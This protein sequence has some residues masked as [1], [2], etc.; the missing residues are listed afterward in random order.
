M[1]SYPYDWKGTNPENAFH[2]DW[3]V[4][5]DDPENRVLMLKHRPF[6]GTGL[7]V[8]AAGSTNPLTL[9]VDYQLAYQLPELEDSVASPVFCGV[10]LLNPLIGGALEITGQTLGDTFYSPFIDMLDD[11]VKYLNNPVDVD[12]LKLDGRPTLYPA[13]PAATSWADLLNKKYLASA[14]RDVELDAGAANDLIRDKLAALKTTVEGLQTEIAAFNYP[15]H[16]AEHKAHDITGAQTGAHPAN[17][18]TPDT[19]LAYGKTLRTLTAEI[20]ALGLQQSDIDNYIEKWACKDVNGVFVQTL[21]ANRQLFKSKSGTSEITFTDTAFTIKTNGSVILS[22]GYDEAATV[23]FMEWK[24]GVNTLR[25]E[26]SGSAL[27][28]DKLTLNDRVLLTTNLLLEYQSD[29]SEGGNTDPDDNKLWVQGRNGLSFTGKGSRADPVKGTLTPPVASTTVKGITKLK[30][31]PGPETNL[32]STPA[33]L[34]PYE[35][36][37]SGYVPKTTMINSGAMDTGSRTLVKADIGLGNVDNTK[38][39]DKPISQEQQVDL[40]ELSIK[41]HK[42]AWDELLLPLASNN[43]KGIARYTSLEDGL[44][45]QK[46]VAPNLLKALS[47][48]LDIVAAA[49]SDVKTGASTDFAAVDASTWTV[50]GTKRGLTVQDMDYFYLSQ[51]EKKSGVVSGTIDLQ[52]TPMFQWFSPYNAMERTWPKSV[53]NGTLAW[54]GISNQPALPLL[55]V[56]VGKTVGQM[57]DL[58]V[59]SILSKERV[60]THTGKLDIYVA[61]GGKVTVYV[62][63]VEKIAANSPAYVNV[64]FDN[65]DGT[66]HTVAI[67]ADCTDVAKPA[68]MMYE[69]WDGKAPLVRSDVGKP[70]AQLQEF[71]TQAD[72]LRHYLYLNMITGSIYSRAEPVESQDID[73]EHA[74]IGYVDLP[75]GGLTVSSVSFPKTFDFGMAKELSD[76]AALVDAHKPQKADWK[77]SDNPAMVPMGRMRFELGCAVYGEIASLGVNNKGMMTFGGNGDVPFLAL[78]E[79]KEQSPLRWVTPFNPKA[80]GHTT[81]E[82]GFTIAATGMFRTTYAPHPGFDLVFAGAIDAAGADY[83]YRRNRVMVWRVDGLQKPKIGFA[84]TLTT[85]STVRATMPEFQLMDAPCTVSVLRSGN[86]ADGAAALDLVSLKKQFP[87]YVIR[88]RYDCHT[89]VLRVFQLFF[90]GSQESINCTEIEVKFDI[91]FHHYLSGFVGVQRPVATGIAEGYVGLPSLMDLSSAGFDDS[92]YHYYRSLFESYVDADALTLT[93]GT[94]TTFNTV[95]SLVPDELL[96]TEWISLPGDSGTVGRSHDGF[97]PSA[98]CQGDQRQGS[99]L[100]LAAGMKWFSAWNATSGGQAAHLSNIT[101]MLKL[102]DD[103][104]PYSMKLTIS[105]TYAGK[106]WHASTGIAVGSWTASPDNTTPQVIEVMVNNSHWVGGSPVF[107]EFTPPSTLRT[108]LKLEFTLKT[109]TNASVELETLTQASPVQLFSTGK[110]YMMVRQNPFHMTEKMWNWLLDR[111]DTERQTDGTDFGGWA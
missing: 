73:I 28:M 36:K 40:D 22:A 54:T 33:S 15:A 9:G 78:W 64:Q 52:T 44:A 38:D 56:P 80:D 89:R 24:S 65:D 106:I 104:A 53:T 39:L 92:K 3:L 105:S 58:S 1:K 90:D 42:H 68:S 62:D 18:K 45:S 12:W 59:V 46:G 86:I 49:V 88:Y 67:R 82:G 51:G 110:R 31:G 16:I 60:V 69:I 108:D 109:Y 10:Q 6:F 97:L 102:R 20:R 98:F 91:E 87:R 74:L 85:N 35:G 37:A 27:G 83:S 23:R 61:A 19:F 81:I 63:G 47:D 21:A 43:Q 55:A 7:V 34:T 48:R 50:T 76:H 77:L 84:K 103:V 13:K 57:G 8:T 72:G 94:N 71:V 70:I 14:V 29:G 111:M 32:A 75:T 2:E 25:I 99:P 95:T 96:S 93:G 107:L 4:D 17:L 26:S 79:A 5:S 66:A 11:L 41:G 100:K 30:T 101:A